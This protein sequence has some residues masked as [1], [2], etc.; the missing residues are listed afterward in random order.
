MS[1]LTYPL[2]NYA[3]TLPCKKHFHNQTLQSI[4]KLFYLP[5]QSQLIPNIFATRNDTNV[6][7]TLV[8]QAQS[9]SIY[10]SPV[11][12][13]YTLVHPVLK[14]VLFG[15]SQVNIKEEYFIFVENNQLIVEVKTLLS[16][17]MLMD[18]FVTRTLYIYSQVSEKEVELEVK[19][20]VEFVKE[21]MFKKVVEKNAYEENEQQ[22]PDVFFKEMEKIIEMKKEKEETKED[23]QDD[24]DDKRS[25][26]TQHIENNDNDETVSYWCYYYCF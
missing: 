13:V 1:L 11:K 7:F 24:E 26:E 3:R 15:P 21:N 10:D 6:E 2:T 17:F 9:T 18:T 12:Y 23:E 25:T 5:Y 19:L 14:K 8:Q 20:D 4:Y 16:G 22:I